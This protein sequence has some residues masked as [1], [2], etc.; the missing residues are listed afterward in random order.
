MVVEL[1][2]EGRVGEHV[3][4]AWQLR[5]RHDERDLPQSQAV[6]DVLLV[7]V[8]VPDSEGAERLLH[9]GAH[10]SRERER[11]PRTIPTEK[12]RL[13]QHQLDRRGVNLPWYQRWSGRPGRRQRFGWMRRGWWRRRRRRRRWQRGWWLRG[14]WWRSRGVDGR[15][16]RWWRSGRHRWHRRRWARDALWVARAVPDGDADGHCQDEDPWQ[17]APQRE[18]RAEPPQRRRHDS[19]AQLL[20]VLVD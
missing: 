14:H 9:D 15:W 5:L 2:Q 3:L 10:V 16:R 8:N 20:V 11:A 17:A 19:S 4:V 13:G 7:Q 12:V 18:A 1:R 6:R